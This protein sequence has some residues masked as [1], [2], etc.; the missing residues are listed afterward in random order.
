M[1]FIHFKTETDEQARMLEQLLNNINFVHDVEV[2]KHEL[3]D[4]TISK[5]E[6]S[7]EIY[8]KDPDSFKN[9]DDTKKNLLNKL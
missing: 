2:N 5:L 3:N 1:P 4:F 7:A 8:K 6:E 9:W